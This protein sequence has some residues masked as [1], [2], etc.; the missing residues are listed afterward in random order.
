MAE[1]QLKQNEKVSVVAEFFFFLLTVEYIVWEV[2]LAIK[3]S[4][5]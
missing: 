3:Q 5:L 1:D 4:R 2:L